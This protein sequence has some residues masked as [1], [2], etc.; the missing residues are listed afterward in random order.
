MPAQRHRQTNARCT[1][2][3]RRN[4]GNDI[5]LDTG[6]THRSHF[7]RCPAKD[8]SIPALQTHNPMTEQGFTNEQLVDVVLFSRRAI[9]RLPGVDNPRTGP[10]QRQDRLGDQ[11][12]GHEDVR[13]RNHPA[14]FDRQKI[15]IT[16]P[17]SDQRHMPLP[18]L[19]SLTTH[20]VSG[21]RLPT[22]RSAAFLYPNKK[23]FSI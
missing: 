15:R 20:S 8:K 5:D 13:P 1:C 21:S 16:G 2:V 12:V 23:Q 6:S 9:G 19:L 4:P 7:F 22:A 18:H 10:G 14:S 3:R 11:P 17:A